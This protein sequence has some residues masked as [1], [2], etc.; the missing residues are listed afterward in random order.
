MTRDTMPRSA[1][2]AQLAHGRVRRR[3]GW[4]SPEPIDIRP[5]LPPN[6]PVYREWLREQGI[7]P[8]SA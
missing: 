6:A 7:H 4:E 5:H 1:I 3:M 8:I 2:D